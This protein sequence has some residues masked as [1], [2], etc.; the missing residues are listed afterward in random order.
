MCLCVRYI[1]NTSLCTLARVSLYFCEA[2]IHDEDQ[3]KEIE[4]EKENLSSASPLRRESFVG[5]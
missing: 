1:I 5:L 2:P 4:S 3:E